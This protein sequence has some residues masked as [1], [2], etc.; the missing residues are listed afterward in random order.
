M[1]FL[2]NLWHHNDLF[3][4][5]NLHAKNPYITGSSVKYDTK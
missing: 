3:M 2:S 1:K 4:G 5:K